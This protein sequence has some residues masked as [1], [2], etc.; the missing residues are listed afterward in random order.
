MTLDKLKKNIFSRINEENNKELLQLI[1]TLLEEKATTVDT[2]KR[3]S[4]KQYNKEIQDAMK[5]MDEGQYLTQEQVEQ[6]M[7]KW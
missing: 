1:Y 7:A 2:G 6:L 4:K 5:Q 3:I